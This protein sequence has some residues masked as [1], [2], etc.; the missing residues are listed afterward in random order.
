[1][2]KLRRLGQWQERLGGLESGIRGMG[3][4]A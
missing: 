1:M 2:A 4:P 3:V